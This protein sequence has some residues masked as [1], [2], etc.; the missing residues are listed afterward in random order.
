METAVTR[1]QMATAQTAMDAADVASAKSKADA[2]EALVARFRKV[3]ASGRIVLELPPADAQPKDL[4]DVVLEDGDRFMVPAKPS[5]V[6]VMGM[7]YTPNAFIYRSGKSAGDYIDQ[8]GGATRDA[9]EDREYILRA[10]GSVLSAQSSSSFW[11]GSFR[12]NTLM[13]GD[14]VIVPELLDKFAFSKSLKDASQIFY[15]FALGVAGIK[16]L[17]P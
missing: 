16:V 5:T 1:E 11:G 7:V 6:S 8:A 12:K 9:D 2:Q 14:T 3:Q 15:Q 4:P 17:F 13:P 10:D